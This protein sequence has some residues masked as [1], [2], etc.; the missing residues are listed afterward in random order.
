MAWDV[1]QREGGYTFDFGNSK[2]EEL[3]LGNYEDHYKHL[4]DLEN[5]SIAPTVEYN[6]PGVEHRKSYMMPMP[7]NELPNPVDPRFLPDED[8]MGMIRGGKV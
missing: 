2:P 3:K 1:L 8:V 7:F 4:K 6:T 5:A